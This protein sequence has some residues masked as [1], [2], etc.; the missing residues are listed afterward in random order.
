M[1]T[2]SQ[3]VVR[4]AIPRAQALVFQPELTHSVWVDV[5]HRKRSRKALENMLRKRV[6]SG[7]YIGYR[8]I[9]IET[10]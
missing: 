6:N 1:T 10:V 8:M 3:Q 2:D 7:E 4:A 9:T 5:M